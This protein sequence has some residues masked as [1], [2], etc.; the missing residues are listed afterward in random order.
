MSVARRNVDEDAYREL[1]FA[2][3]EALPATTLIQVET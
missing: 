3:R 1:S 2:E